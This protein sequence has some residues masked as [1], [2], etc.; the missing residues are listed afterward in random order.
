MHLGKMTNSKT[1][2]TILIEQNQQSIR[3]GVNN[4]LYRDGFHHSC[5]YEHM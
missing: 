4:D 3:T 1:T 2:F 5:A